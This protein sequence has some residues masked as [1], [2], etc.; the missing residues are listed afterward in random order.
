MKVVIALGSNVGDTNSHLHHAIE[1][2]GH[3]IEITAVSSFHKTA[4]MGGPV[5]N[6]YL[7]AVLLAQSD[8]DPLDLLVLMQ[9][10]E[11]KAGRT[12]EIHWGPRTLDL[13]L[14]SFGEL[15]L[16]DPHLTLP[17]PFAHERSFVLEPWLEIDPTGELLGYGSIS[18]LLSALKG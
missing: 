18:E 1:E 13:D 16:N 14:I 2:L 5:Q 7:N 4:P 9:D 6:D 12:R 11:L 10:I 8:M 15:V 17:H 3:H